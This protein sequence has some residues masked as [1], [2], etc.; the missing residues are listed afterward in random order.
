[1]KLLRTIG[2]RSTE[3]RGAVLLYS[4]ML[5]V[6]IGTLAMSLLA[7]G[8]GQ[9]RE[10]ESAEHELRSFYVAEAG[11][12]EAYLDMMGGGTGELGSE[13]APIAQGP[14][15]YWVT[16]TDLGGQT[17]LV[18]TGSANGH[19]TRVELVVQTSQSSVFDFA[20]FGDDGVLVNSN[21]MTDSYDPGAGSYA[22]QVSG[23]HAGTAG[24]IGSN[25]DI[26]LDAN[27]EVWGDAAPGP[28][29]VVDN[30]APGANISGSTSSSPSS[31]SL[32]AIIVPSFPS[33]GSINTNSNP[34]IGPGDVAYSSITMKANGLLT[35]VGPARVVVDDFTLRSN[36]DLII[37]SAS[38]P[39]EIFVT[40]TFDLR[41][42]STV[43]TTGTSAADLS[44]NLTADNWGAGDSGA[45]IAFNSNGEFHGTVYAPNA[46]LTIDSNFEVYGSIVGDFI[47]LSS[48]TQIHYDETLAGGVMSGTPTGVA[49]WRVLPD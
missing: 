41:S 42:N 26:T 35:I 30:S 19:E 20:A 29:G 39:V 8:M 15:A 33:S 5:S 3:R 16:A 46:Y 21:A 2:G 23:S 49:L 28:T 11:I 48:N 17:S 44:L 24:D 9:Q 32:P 25:I 38:G 13:N 6:G 40:N 1:M 31:I 43:T 22:S 36:S 10:Q 7:V 14:H 47:E 45:T 27:T 18:A 37:D 34:T 12:N 4:A